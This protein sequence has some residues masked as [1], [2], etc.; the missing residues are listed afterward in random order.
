[1]SL[2]FHKKSSRCWSIVEILD[3]TDILIIRENWNEQM[4]FQ[5]MIVKDSCFFCGKKKIWLLFWASVFFD[6]EIRPMNSRHTEKRPSTCCSQRTVGLKLDLCQIRCY[7]KHFFK[8]VYT[9]ENELFSSCFKLFM[10]T[11]TG[12]HDEIECLIIVKTSR[13]W[14]PL[15][16]ARGNFLLCFV[17]FGW[18]KNL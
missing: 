8:I 10:D 18:K 13:S 7:S 3:V 9:L 6:P 1:M 14:T 17:R 4:D 5:W 2:N 16:C 15:C 11:G 12:F